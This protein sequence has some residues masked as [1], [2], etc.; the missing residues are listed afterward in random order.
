MSIIAASTPDG[1]LLRQRDDLEAQFE[2]GKGLYRIAA[3]TVV[4]TTA[5]D[6]PP[7]ASRPITSMSAPD[8]TRARWA[9]IRFF[10]SPI[11]PYAIKSVAS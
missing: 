11:S 9:P 2:V 6:F 3:T 7:H 1:R 4:V 10:G 8:M 5:I